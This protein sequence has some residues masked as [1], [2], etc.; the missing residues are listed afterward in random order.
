MIIFDVGACVGVYTD[1]CLEIY[2][3]ENIEKIYLF[4]PLVANLEHLIEK[5]E[6]MGEKI[7]IIPF[8]V[9]NYI[10]SGKLNVK[11]QYHLMSDSEKKFI[12]ELKKV[13]VKKGGGIVKIPEEEFSRVSKSMVNAGQYVSNS[14]CCLNM[15]PRQAS[16]NSNWAGEG[17]SKD[18]TGEIYH[19][20]TYQ[21]TGVCTID[22]IL[23]AEKL[24]HIDILKLDV[25]GS[26]Y[27]IM[28]DILKKDT[29]KKIGKVFFEDHSEK[30]G[31]GNEVRENIFQKIKE[32]NIENQF[33]IQNLEDLAYDIPLPE[34]D[35]WR[36]WIDRSNP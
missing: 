20:M 19:D 15:T 10:G 4:E 22:W 11:M 13:I 3:E 25:E 7:I 35:M 34:S 33:W 14:G 23:H 18:G 9:S 16:I 6:N 31:F 2:G 8:A 32:R 26:E 21:K 12:D 36:E 29:Y 1:Y 30:R 28:E 5:Y 27:D 24:D 17:D